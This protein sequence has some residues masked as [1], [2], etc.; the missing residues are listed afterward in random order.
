MPVAFWI[1]QSG[2]SQIANGSEFQA[3]QAA[4]QTWQNVPIA[5]VSF[6]Y[7]GATPV[8]TVGQDGMSVVTFVDNSVPIGLET[9]AATFSFF[10]AD[11]TGNLSIQEADIALSTSV[12]FSTS[13]DPSKYDLQSVVTHEVGHLLGLNHSTLVSSVMAPYPA[14]GQLDQRTL[15]SDDMIGVATLYPKN[16]DFNTLSFVTGTVTSAGNPVFGAQLVILDS[17]G[18][19]VAS[20]ISNQDGSYEIDFVAPGTYQLYAAPLNGPVTEQNIGGNSTSYYSGLQTGF[21]TTYYGDVA[22]L[23]SASTIQTVAGRTA[24]NKNIHV[25]SAGPLGIT[26]P[27]TYAAHISTGSQGALTL[28]GSGLASGDTFSVSNSG[29]TLGAPVYGGS[30]ASNAPTSAQ[31]PVTVSATA[32]LGPKDIAV[33]ANG[34]TSVLSGGIVIVNPQPSSIVVAPTSGT[35]DGGTGVSISGQNFRSGAQVFFG[36]LP[37]TNVQVVNSTT[38]QA[39]TPTNAAGGTNVVVVNSDGTWGVETNAFTYSGL[40]PQISNVSPLSGPPATLVNITGAEFSSRIS[41]VAVLFNG[42]PGTVVSTSR[43]S[44]TAVVPFSATTGVVTVNVAGQSVTG[45]VFTVTAAPVSTNL[46]LTTTKFIDATAGGTTLTFVNNDDADTVTTLPFSFTLFDKTY[47]A[48]ST[49]AVSI[50]GWL[51]LDAFTQPQFKNGTLPGSTLPPALIAPFFTDLFLPGGA[52]IS[53]QVVGAAPNRQ[54]VVEWLNAGILDGQAKDLGSSVT[55]EAVLYEG[56]NDIQFVYG[57]MTGAKSDASSATVGIQNS[58]RTQAVQ[59]GYNQSVVS[60]GTVVAYHFASG[61]YVAP[62]PP[63]LPTDTPYSIPNLG[64]LSVITDGTGAATI[65]GFATV[66]PSAGSTTPSGVSIFGYRPGG[67]LVSETGV[68]A[69]PLLTNG[70]IYAEIAGSV[71][72]GLA[73]ANPNGQQATISYY[74]TDATGTDSHNGT[75]TIAANGHLAEF[76]ND[77]SLNGV[78]NFQGSF[79]LSSNVPVAVIALR[80]FLN[81]RGETLLST[82]PVSDLSAAVASTTSVLP[83]F[84]DG[85]GWTTQIILVNPTNST[86]TGNITFLDMNGQQVAASTPFSIPQHSSFKLSTPGTLSATQ[87][88]SVQ[89]IPGAGSNTPTPVAIFSNRPNGVTVSQAAVLPTTGTALRMYVEGAGTSGASGNI[90]SGVALANVGGSATTVTLSLTDLSGKALGTTTIQVA[91]NGQLA[92]FVSDMF[93]SISLPFKGVLR[94]SSSGSALAVAELRVRVNERG[95][96][97]T[98]TTPPTNENSIASTAPVIFPQIANGGG[99]T[100]QFVLF[101]GTANQTASG[102]L[103][104]TYAN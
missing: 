80:S 39:V 13:G 34:V 58:A 79:T 36:G 73:I 27:N 30:I 70:R 38:I 47:Q 32:S 82:L 103:H 10:A 3:I 78:S 68:P 53:T 57:T 74:F 49:I 42:V 40:P 55:F 31:L 85:S 37:A 16:A 77:P 15:S 99:F 29:V 48:G 46:A 19:P 50:N 17:T 2:S 14:A 11:A 69:S 43:T 41:D 23:S 104:L 45:P 5:N 62:T 91:A 56:S 33:S 24:S 18:T 66:T 92:K 8:S 25:L 86:M 51:S 98:S 96:Y 22:T 44:V 93:P 76:L 60:T 54:F 97:L 12:G 35:V 61:T 28:G 4:F 90:L 6:Q 9:V 26:V 95:D 1:N 94:V 102:V 100:T 71:N 101:S 63:I 75:L 72:T 7:K 83:H 81:E 84:A 20:T 88:G 52:S 67:V 65:T 59:T 89:I 87:T 21:A 64:G